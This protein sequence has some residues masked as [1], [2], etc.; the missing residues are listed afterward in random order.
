MVSGWRGSPSIRRNT[1]S[2]RGRSFRRR[3]RPS[4]RRSAPLDVTAALVSLTILAPLLA[5]MA[6]A[7]WLESKGPIF[8]GDKR[9][10]EGGRVF[11]CWKFRTMFTGADCAQRQ[12][13]ALNN[14]DGPHFK[15]D[16]DPRVTRVGRVL[17]APQRRRV[18]AAV[19]RADRRNEPRRTAAVAVPRKSGL[20][21]V[22]RSPA[23]GVAR[24]H[25]VLAGL[26][27]RTGRRR[28]PSVDRVRPALRAVL[29]VLARPEDPRR[30]PAHPGRQGDARA[31][32][33]APAWDA[34]R[35][36]AV[37]SPTRS[38]PLDEIAAENTWAATGQAL[39]ADRSDAKPL[40][41]AWARLCALESTRLT[42][43]SIMTT[44]PGCSRNC[45]ARP[46]PLVSDSYVKWMRVGCGLG[47]HDENSILVGESE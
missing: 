5:L 28:L 32:I 47:T 1:R 6:V 41:E 12:L 3:R 7:V 44:S 23:V 31:G 22:A 2:R 35:R 37:Y 29:L 43:H 8:F 13:N 20:R 42:I 39:L 18:A 34:C 11:R 33:L 14:T 4:E 27:A 10:G 25:R 45:A 9:E 24:H 21:A 26:P 30:Y 38:G 40:G 19:Q 36:A 15:V 16:R 46:A 17:R